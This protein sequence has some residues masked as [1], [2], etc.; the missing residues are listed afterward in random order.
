MTLVIDR[1]TPS[2][3]V[4]GPTAVNGVGRGWPTVELT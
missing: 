2:L 3:P 1:H 4:P